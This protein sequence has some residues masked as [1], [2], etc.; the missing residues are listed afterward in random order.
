MPGPDRLSGLVCVTI[1]HRL[2]S[3]IGAWVKC[4]TSEVKWPMFMEMLCKSKVG[5]SFVNYSDRNNCIRL[6]RG[7]LFV[8]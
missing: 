6:A 5:S 8:Y 7:I 2:H 4:S 1:R 3:E